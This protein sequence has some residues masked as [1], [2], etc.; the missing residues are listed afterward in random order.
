LLVL[1]ESLREQALAFDLRPVWV[2]DNICALVHWRTNF[3]IAWSRV[4][5]RNE[6][7]VF[8]LWNG[9]LMGTAPW[10]ILVEIRIL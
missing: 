5:R 9:I 6:R 10:S 1:V 3:C 2:Y 7:T 4:E 8:V